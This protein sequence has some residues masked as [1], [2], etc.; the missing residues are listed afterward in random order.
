MMGHSMDFFFQI[1]LDRESKNKFIYQY[2]SS[3]FRQNIRSLQKE[4]QIKDRVDDFWTYL[5]EW[6]VC[7]SHPLSW[8]VWAGFFIL[9]INKTSILSL[10]DFYLLLYLQG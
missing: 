3:L 2:P 8:Q 6:S 4:P 1:M 7:S 5:N 10:W 9:D